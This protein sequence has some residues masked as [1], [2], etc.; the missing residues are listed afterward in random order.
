MGP[1]NWHGCAFPSLSVQLP[2]QDG[3]SGLSFSVLHELVVAP[4]QPQA[5]KPP[6]P[7]LSRSSTKP[8]FWS[9]APSSTW[10]FTPG[11]ASTRSVRLLH[12]PASLCRRP[13]GAISITVG[14]DCFAQPLRMPITITIATCVFILV[15][16][17][18]KELQSIV[19]Y[20]FFNPPVSD[21]FK[22]PCASGLT[23]LTGSCTEASFYW[24]STTFATA[25]SDA[26]V[27]SL[28]IGDVLAIGKDG[29][30]HVRAVRGGSP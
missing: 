6:R 25:A 15:S 21:A 9:P 30:L 7:P 27:V 28:F 29:L 26:W 10:S 2:L 11:D 22:T 16:S 23:V 17:K 13:T 24:S 8:L 1:S 19:N 3:C 4:T 20:Q 5:E 18:S 14:G 12:S